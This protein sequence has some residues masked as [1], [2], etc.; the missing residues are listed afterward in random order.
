MNKL[1]ALRKSIFY[2]S[3]PFSF[4]GFMLPLYAAS[5]G[6]SAVEI[7]FLYSIFSL[8]TILIRPAVGRLIDNKGRKVGVVVGIGLYCFSNLLFLL[9]QN[10]VYLLFA[11]GFQSLGASFLWIS[12]S[13]IVSDIS[14]NQN[15]SENFGIINQTLNKG[16]FIGVLIGFYIL[17]N[18]FFENPFKIIFL[19]YLLTSL[20]SLYN[21]IM[22][23]EDTIGYKEDYEERSIKDMKKLTY[24]LLAVG[25]L[26]FLFS[27]TSSIYLIYVKENITNKL[28]LISYLFLPEAILSLF[29]PK[30]FGRIADRMNRE[31]IMLIGILTIGIFYLLIPL[32]K[33]YYTFMIIHTLIVIV[34]MFYGPAQSA[35]II[36]FVG[37]NQRGQS[38]GMYNFAIGIGGIFGPIIGAYIY[39]Y[40]GNSIIFYTQG[41]S[42]IIFIL[43]FL[44]IQTKGRKR[45]DILGRKTKEI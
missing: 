10:Y 32:T 14:F 22:T 8:F 15:R 13:T 28:Y 37:E 21:S 3:F 43:A 38:Y 9:S 2:I 4:I 41:I 42:L 6:A 23:V 27:L 31:K 18:N 5:I 30:I 11:R 29:L 1:K 16:R 12:V 25:I 45:E 44:F 33:D 17:F 35:L 24:F 34:S 19:I 20:F 26:S 40:L 36:D 7:G 39:Q